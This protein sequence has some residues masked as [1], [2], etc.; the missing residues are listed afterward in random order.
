MKKQTRN[1]FTVCLDN[2][3]NVLNAQGIRKAMKFS[4]TCMALILLVPDPLLGQ[5]F[6]KHNFEKLEGCIELTLHLVSV[7][8]KKPQSFTKIGSRVSWLWL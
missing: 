8:F 4:T 5:Q 3:E 7:N 1:T 2:S 6:D